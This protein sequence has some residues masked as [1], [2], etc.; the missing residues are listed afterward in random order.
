MTDIDRLIEKVELA[1]ISDATGD[2]A[3]RQIVVMAGAAPTLAAELK[4]LREA[5]VDY[6]DCDEAWSNAYGAES[7]EGCVAEAAA[8]ELARRKVFALVGWKEAR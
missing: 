6:F 2:D 1:Q 7:D 3:L 5:V 4:A 8:L